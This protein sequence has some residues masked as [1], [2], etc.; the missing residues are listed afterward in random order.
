[1]KG[2]FS[3]GVAGAGLAAVLSLPAFAGV[4]TYKIDPRHSSANFAVTHLMISTV[5]GEFHA[6]NGTVTVDDSDLA[7]SSV[8]V[9]IDA[10]TVDTREP[11]RDKDL[12]S[13]NFFDVEK[14][15]AIT[16]KST[17]VEKSPV[18]GH[19]KVTGDLTLH[20]VTKSVTLD[21]TSPKPA[22]KDPWGLQRTAVSGSTKINRQDFGMNYSKTLDNGGLMVSNDVDITLDVEMI[23]P[24]P[25]K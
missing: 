1:M 4:T 16:F 5:R 2:Y 22:I 7:K 19:L 6:V 25:A 10:S 11:D 15:P 14:Y 23:V 17:K 8:E 3:K 24:P 13:P 9:T 12:K 20:G 18:P 21:V